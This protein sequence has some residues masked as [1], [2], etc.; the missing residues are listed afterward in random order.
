[1]S[2]QKN[3]PCLEERYTQ[4][5]TKLMVEMLLY[6][7]LVCCIYLFLGPMYISESMMKLAG[8]LLTA[9]LFVALVILIRSLLCKIRMDE[10]GVDV[11]NPLGG[12]TYLRWDEINTAAVVV[13]TVKG[14][15]TQPLIVLAAPTPE[16]VLTFAALALGKG[17]SKHEHVRIPDSP[18]RRE[19]IEHYLHMTLPDIT[20]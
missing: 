5:V 15:K 18:K 10:N 9:S 17:L 19:V 6:F 7:G 14:Q 2:E 11:D 13:L 3:N 4:R 12:H 20:L 16:E 1:M 8:L